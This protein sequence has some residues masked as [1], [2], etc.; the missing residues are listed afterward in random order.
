MGMKDIEC[1]NCE[2]KK[3]DFKCKKDIVIH[4]LFEVEHFLCNVKKACNT[5]CLYKILK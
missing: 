5:M 3:F 4:S 2:K 1:R